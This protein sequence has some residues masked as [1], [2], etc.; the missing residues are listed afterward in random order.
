VCCEWICNIMRSSISSS[1]IQKPLCA[2][3]NCFFPQSIGKLS[4]ELVEHKGV[5]YSKNYIVVH[6][7]CFSWRPNFPNWVAEL[8]R[9]FISTNDSKDPTRENE[10]GRLNSKRPLL[11]LCKYISIWGFGMVTR[12]E[13]CQWNRR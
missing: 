9:T 5:S 7:F 11:P 10:W 6:I 12:P 2:C 3:A 13:T 1:V 8:L 4:P